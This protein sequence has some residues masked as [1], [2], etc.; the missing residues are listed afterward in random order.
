MLNLQQAIIVQTTTYEKC[1]ED[2]DSV[3]TMSGLDRGIH[4]SMKLTSFKKA[5]TFRH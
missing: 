5:I 2:E 4:V 1:L 3:E